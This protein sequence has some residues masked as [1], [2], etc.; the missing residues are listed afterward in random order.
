[1]ATFKADQI[2]EKS[3]LLPTTHHKNKFKAPLSFPRNYQIVTLLSVIDENPSDEDCEGLSIDSRRQ[4]FN[5]E[6][7]RSWRIGLT[8]AI[9]SGLLFTATN[10]LIQYFAVE[11][12]EILLVRSLFQV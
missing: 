9:A 11:A 5:V 8:L 7:I 6:L 4:S 1:M 10:F 2:D 3:K 12:L